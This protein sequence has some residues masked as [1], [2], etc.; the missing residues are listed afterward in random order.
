MCRER[1]PGTPTFRAGE[2]VIL[3][4]EK[5]TTDFAVCGL[6]QGVFRVSHST[7]GP[8]V[9]RDLSGAAYAQFHQ[10]GAYEFMH[11]APHG[12]KGLPLAQ[13]KA[14]INLHLVEQGKEVQP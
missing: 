6:Q 14:E 9:S 13:L 5:N 3:F 4:L 12:V 11:D 1:V 8:V 2:E 7:E 10:D